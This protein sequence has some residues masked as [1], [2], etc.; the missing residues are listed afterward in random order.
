MIF[1]LL[2]ITIG[3]GIGIT[4]SFINSLNKEIEEGNIVGEDLWN[5]Y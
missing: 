5:E 2:Y 4:A 1:E 3:I